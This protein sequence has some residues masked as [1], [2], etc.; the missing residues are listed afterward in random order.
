MGLLDIFQWPSE[1]STSSESIVGKTECN[2]NN[3]GSMFVGMANSMGLSNP[4]G[5]VGKSGK[6]IRLSK[7]GQTY[8]LTLTMYKPPI[9]VSWTGVMPMDKLVEILDRLATDNKKVGYLNTF[10]TSGQQFFQLAIG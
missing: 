1:S 10:N 9:T 2:F 8:T 6:G 5:L 3:L 4:A 7:K